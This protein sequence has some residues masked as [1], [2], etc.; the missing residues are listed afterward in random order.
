MK[1]AT[2]ELIGNNDGYCSEPFKTKKSTYR[3]AKLGG[4][5][6]SLCLIF[7]MFL[8][9]IRYFYTSTRMHIL[10]NRG[11]FAWGCL[12]GTGRQGMNACRAEHGD[13][14]LPSPWPRALR[15]ERWDPHKLFPCIEKCLMAISVT[16]HGRV[17][18]GIAGRI[19][20][21]MWLLLYD[22]RQLL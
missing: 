22:Y 2:F 21:W 18:N 11:L 20:M 9:S 4:F 10:Q 12:P 14:L 6:H 5:G 19:F 1:G 7:F 17:R 15:L 16:Q 3:S 8:A 13:P